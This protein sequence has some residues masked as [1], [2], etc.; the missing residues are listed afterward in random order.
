MKD[1]YY[2]GY[3]YDPLAG[4][5][6]NWKDPFPDGIP[7]KYWDLS[8]YLEDPKT[9]DQFNDQNLVSG[10]PM[11]G[12]LKNYHVSKESETKFNKT[13]G[14]YGLSFKDVKYPYLTALGSTS[15]AASS[16]ASSAALMVSRNLSRLYN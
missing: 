7:R 14:L 15:Y 3:G 13:L 5:S 2:S 9:H 6:F 4:F 11:M 12:W 8:Y 16:A 10:L 1:G